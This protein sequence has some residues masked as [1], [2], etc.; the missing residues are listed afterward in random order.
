MATSSPDSNRRA[1]ILEPSR[2]PHPPK[3]SSKSTMPISLRDPS[4][5]PSSTT[6]SQDPSSVWSGKVSELSPLADK[7]SAPPTPWP[8]IPEQS[9]VTSASSL[10]ETSATGQTPPKTQRRKSNSGS[11]RMSLN[12]NTTATT[13]STND[14]QII[15]SKFPSV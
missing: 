8:P 1:T 12:G 2:W 13:G 5:P 3:N 11:A 9:E 4:S 10:E 6:C 7:S 15:Y 14:S